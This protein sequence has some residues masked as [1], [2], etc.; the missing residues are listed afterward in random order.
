M[1]SHDDNDSLYPRR[2]LNS[3]NIALEFVA[4]T[5]TYKPKLEEILKDIITITD[6]AELAIES[7]KIADVIGMDQSSPN[8]EEQSPNGEDLRYSTRR[9]GRLSVIRWSDIK[10]QPDSASRKGSETNEEFS[11]PSD[12][13]EPERIDLEFETEDEEIFKSKKLYGSSVGS[14]FATRTLL[15]KWDEPEVKGEKVR[16]AYTAEVYCFASYVGFQL[17]WSF[18]GKDVQCICGQYYE[19]QA[20]PPIHEPRLSIFRVIWFS[21]YTK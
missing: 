7:D 5:A 1:V 8:S 10:F 4:L 18:F 9:R 13:G 14:R 3:H 11:L 2:K 20:S 12:D 21:I 6:V 16:I 19:V 17:T 15:D